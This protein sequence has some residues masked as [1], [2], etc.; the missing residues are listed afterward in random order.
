MTKK[1][2]FFPVLLFGLFTILIVT[3]LSKSY[4]YGSYID[5]LSQH[6]R[7]AETIRSACLNQKTLLPSFLPL[8]GGSNGYQFSYYG[9]LRPDILIGC[10]FPAIPMVYFVIGCILAG[11]F[12]SV[13]VCFY[14]LCSHNADRIS[15]FMGSVLFMT[16]TCFYHT[17]RQIM[18]VNYMPFLLLALL[19]VKRKHIR[20]LP[21]ILLLIYVNSFYYAISCLV[22]IGWYWMRLE[23]R[24][25][26]KHGFLYFLKSAL[27][28]IG[29]A[30]MLLIPTAC[31]ILEHRRAADSLSLSEISGLNIHFKSLLYSPYGMGLTIICLYSLLLGLA[32]KKYRADSIFL[33]IMSTSY[34]ASW[35]LNGTLYTRPK[36][37]IPFMPLVILLTTRIFS[38]LHKDSTKKLL[39][40]RKL[41]PC[42]ILFVALPIL[43][44][45]KNVKWVAADIAI[46]TLVIFT[47]KQKCYALSAVCLLIM[48][49]IFYLHTMQD[50][51]FVKKTDV[52]TQEFPFENSIIENWDP[53]YRYDSIV[54]VLNT[55]NLAVNGNLQKS[56]MYSSITNKAY[57]N[58]YYDTFLSPVQINNKVAILPSENP[59]LLHF[60]GIRYLETTEDTLPV[61]YQIISKAEPYVLAENKNVLPVAYVTNSCISETQFNHLSNYNKLDAITRFTVTPDAKPA[62]FDTKMKAYTPVFQDTCLPDSIKIKHTKEGYMVTVDKLTDITLKLNQSITDKI[63]LLDFKVENKGKKAVVIDINHIRNKLSSSSAP[64]PNGNTTFHYQFSDAPK[65]EF[66]TFSI[67]LSEGKYLIKDI[68]WHTYDNL[69]LN[70]KQYTSVQYQN[71]EGNEILSCTAS[72]AENGYF[73]TSIPLQKGMKIYIDGKKVPI[74]KVNQ[75]FAGTRLKKGEHDIRIVFRPPGQMIGYCI[76]MISF[77]ICIGMLVF[78]LFIGSDTVQCYAWHCVNTNK[79][80]IRHKKCPPF[81]H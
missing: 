66:D 24:S 30:A 60:M 78:R 4:F 71:A 8:G 31:V 47:Q 12:C 5:W 15:A 45:H 2:Y 59:F 54:N 79:A 9:Y 65:N 16:A 64:Y 1:K 48:P 68:N 46:L 41:W 53:L 77:L 32:W 74:L 11:Y 67:T 18:F 19:A 3:I 80:T 28:S 13:I 49:C 20:W 69:L 22:V 61:G 33:F 56:A 36:I 52:F 76:S 27:L 40:K 10:L 29:M 43:S 39:F 35:I 44:S 50:E 63:L 75:A 72:A 21:L 81:F 73:V 34:I 55:G 17:H 23:G 6:V 38:D 51:Q 58:V 7:L 37:L 62:E 42:L 25:F 26:W 57:S 70:Q 14:W